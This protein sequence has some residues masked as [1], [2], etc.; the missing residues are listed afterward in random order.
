MTGDR[1]PD[2]RQPDA[3][4]EFINGSIAIMASELGY[5][6]KQLA[7]D[8]VEE[9]ARELSDRYQEHACRCGVR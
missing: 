7:L 9:C 3:M 8:D 5:H 4:V 1:L 2:D 6:R